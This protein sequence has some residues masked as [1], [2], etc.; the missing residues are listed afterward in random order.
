MTSQEWSRPEYAEIAR[1]FGMRTGTEFSAA[2]RRDAE[3]GIDRAMGRAGL[4]DRVRYRQ[5]LESDTAL[6]DDLVV[7]LMVGE[8]Y[9]FRHAEQME[10]IRGLVLPDMVRRKPPR[11]PIR[12]WSAGCASGEEAY[13]LAI[14]FDREQ[15]LPRLELLASD[16]SQQ[17]LAKA[18]QAVYGKWSLRETDSAAA[19][20]YLVP[21]G[22]KFTLRAAI[23][24]R[25]VF[26]RLNLALD[27]YPVANGTKGQD[28]ILCRN[29]LIYF[30]RKT[31]ASVARR[32]FDALSPG[33]WLIT[34]P[35]DPI[36]TE[37]A[38][39]D[40]V[41]TGAGLFYRRGPFPPDSQSDVETWGHGSELE[42][43]G[44]SF[45]ETAI[46]VAP[47][48]SA[49]HA[50]ADATRD[51]LAEARAALERRDYMLAVRLARESPD[52]PAACAVHARALGAIDPRQAAS[53]C[54]QFAARHPLAAELHYLR[55]VLLLELGQV[56][57][58]LL[59]AERAAYLDRSLALVHFTLGSIRQR[60]GDLAA[61]RRDYR[62]ARDLCARRP[63]DEIV[64]LSDGECCGRLARAAEDRLAALERQEARR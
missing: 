19:L 13:S 41:M 46:D 12:V 57:D 16:I 61:A 7:E 53:C 39:F 51:V 54:T 3:F 45:T 15:L 34:A 8:T 24:E 58:A 47:P 1:L 6:F 33:G 11:E 17:A 49:E 21:Q 36:L 40:V 27:S 64:P 35:A 22:S 44:P 31:V 28:L 25:V 26:R 5:R 59:A 14:L 43:V 30:D 48:S 55:A 50:R 62:N 29:V 20:P 18:R 4:S 56:G 9:F 32:L 38:P 10:L 60:Q 2:R 23:R 63:R 42:S 52:D 37:D